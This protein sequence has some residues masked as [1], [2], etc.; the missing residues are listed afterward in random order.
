VGGLRRNIYTF[1][2]WYVRYTN[3][4]YIED[5]DTAEDLIA[6]LQDKSVNFDE[7][8]IDEGQDFEQ[9]FIETAAR[10]CSQ[11]SIG[12]DS[13]QKIHQHGIDSSRIERLVEENFGE[14][15]RFNLLHNYRNN[16]ETYFFAIHFVPDN[17]RAAN[18]VALENIE[19]GRENNLPVIF[20]AKT[21]S[22]TLE[23][24]STRLRDAGEVNV[25]VLLYHT[26]D[27]DRYFN[28]ITEMGF[29]CS[30]YHSDMTDQ[31]KDTTENN[32][33]N[34]LVTTYK[35]AKGMEFQVVIMPDMQE[36]K[37][38]HFMTEEHYYVA[39]TRARENLYLI[40]QGEIPAYLNTFEKNSYI[41]RPHLER[42]DLP[43]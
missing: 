24:L 16:Y 9:R 29:R 25:A 31:E 5:R 17:L 15:E 34:I 36:A 22:D 12:S 3:G 1:H 21:H 42:D 28:E 26:A 40:F 38:A 6:V 4:R 18:T 41:Y 30:R 32:L 7:I 35:S 33:Q 23:I 27:V 43:F 10:T 11:L 13:A 19:R 39:C 14:I 37:T 8:L 20:Q 2:K